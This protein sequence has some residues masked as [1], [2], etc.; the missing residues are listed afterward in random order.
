ME[1]G[2]PWQE[3]FHTARL[4]FISPGLSFIYPF[5]NHC[6]RK[7]T[8]D[9]SLV[10]SY[11]VGNIEAGET[12]ELQEFNK[13]RKIALKAGFSR[14]ATDQWFFRKSIPKPAQIE[15]FRESQGSISFERMESIREAK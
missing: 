8:L 11:R 1:G 2:N 3:T 14:N 13:I 6:N 5:Q 7:I 15:I 10:A 12:M 9:V 4:E